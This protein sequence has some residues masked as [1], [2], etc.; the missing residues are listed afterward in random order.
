MPGK[1]HSLSRRDFVKASVISTAGFAVMST[2]NAL[3]T[4]ANS[5]MTVGLI[6]CGGRGNH[7]AMNLRRH[8]NARITALADPYQDRL[9][10]TK[11]RF[12]ADDPKTFQ[13]FDA[14]EKLLATD[15]DTVIIT[16]P[17]YF[18][19]E[20]FEAAVEA[21]KHV[22]IEKPVAVDTVGAKRV[23]EA[24]KKADGTLTA[25]VGFQTRFR[26]DMVEAV[27]RV[28]DGA[29]GTI[30][31][32]HA[33][34]H[35]GWL[36]TKHKP[37]MS[38]QEKRVRNW[39]FDIVLSGDILVE[40]NIHIL[41]VCN[42]VMQ[43]HPVK[44]YGTG[45]RRIRTAVGD[46]WDH[47]GVTLWYPDNVEVV[48][49]STQFLDL[50]WGDAGERF[51][52]S[53]GAFDALAGPAKIRGENEWSFKGDPGDAEELKVKAFYDS[54]AKNQYVSEIPQGV[55]STLTAIMGRTASYRKVEY[56]WDEMLKE[57]EQFD[58]KLIL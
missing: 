30:V 15:V 18:H 19:P 54:I 57:N 6:G 42:W 51:N 41:D 36:S 40:Q 27:K 50:G 29:I 49:A 32:G 39:V 52:G 20:H 45:G 21:K 25:M 44:A 53:M 38:E 55:E 10:G 12:Q 5:A 16:S 56:T 8:T 24:G 31:C 34:Y 2:E 17:P 1:N 7:D 37:G 28:Q 3:G 43:T 46:T 4:K 35:S 33:H 22:Y 11:R 48:F 13:G 26:P 23:L 14:Y 47:Y 58:A 9:D